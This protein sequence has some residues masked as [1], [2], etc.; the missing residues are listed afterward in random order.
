MKE[1]WINL[2][3]EQLDELNQYGLE[4]G[5]RV[6]HQSELPGVFPDRLRGKIDS[7]LAVTAPT[8]SG[9]TFLVF[10]ALRVDSRDR[11]VDMQPLGLIVHSTGVSSSGVFI[12]HGNW[13][14]RTEPAPAEFWNQVDT[15]GI[16][17]YFSARPPEGRSTGSLEELSIQHRGAFSAAVRAIRNRLDGRK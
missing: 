17:D 7:A 2:S 1:T 16:G 12:D 5:W 9:G 8:S 10:S 14:G 4:P 15:Y 6:L 11:A 3:T 13:P